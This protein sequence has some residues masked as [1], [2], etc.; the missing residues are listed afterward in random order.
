M[1]KVEGKIILYKG[2]K[3]LEE[4]NEAKNASKILDLELIN[5]H[6]YQLSNNFGSRY[7]LEY[8][9]IRSTKEKYPR[10]YAEI[11]KKPL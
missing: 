6:N 11:K 9:K 8:K 7:L 5:A 4:A 10:R 2:D 1:V 3:G